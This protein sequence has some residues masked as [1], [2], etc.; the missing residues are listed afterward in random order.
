M[1]IGRPVPQMIPYSRISLSSPLID[2]V[3]R[4]RR[5]VERY[6]VAVAANAPSSSRICFSG[7]KT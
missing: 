3:R 6:F 7:L 2:R 1:Y 4:R 5:T